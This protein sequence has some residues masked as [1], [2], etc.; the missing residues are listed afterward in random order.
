VWNDCK[1]KY[2]YRYNEHLE[3][4]YEH[5]SGDALE[6]GNFIHKVFELGVSSTSVEELNIISESIRKDYRFS[7][8][9]N[10]KI[11][12]MLDNFIRFNKPLSG[13]I[14]TEMKFE[15]DI[16]FF[17]THKVVLIGK[18]DRVIR[19]GDFFIVID[20]KTS[21]KEENYVDLCKNNQLK[22]YAYAIHRMFNVPLPK[23]LC[24]LYYP[25][26]N[27]H[28]KVKFNDSQIKMHLNNIVRDV[29]KIKKSKK[30]EMIAEKNEFCNW[31]G[32]RKLCYIWE[33]NKI[34]LESNIQAAK[35][36]RD[37]K[38]RKVI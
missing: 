14:A 33:S 19:I 10:T 9:Y 2:H 24:M 3:E 27:N 38:K 11:P 5:G 23:I 16:P 1:L 13:T 18:I 15:V 6:Y 12:V 8:S 21:K 32:F 20:Y 17:T 25:Q 30:S 35:D 28:P 26:T 34:L 4:E 31:C 29:I 37:K 36:K 22:T 7:K